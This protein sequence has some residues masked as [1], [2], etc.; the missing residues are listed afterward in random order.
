M[1]KAIKIGTR[2]SLLALAQATLVQQQLAQKGIDSTLVPLKTS[3]DAFQDKRLA[4]VGGKAL[5]TKEIDRALLRGEIDVAVHSMKDVETT[6]P[7]GLKIAGVLKREDPRD[8]FLSKK[9]SSFD[10]LPPQVRVGTCSPRRAAQVQIRYPQADI[11]LFRGNIHTRLEKLERQEVDV[12]FLALAGL[13]RAKLTSPIG[14]PLDPEIMV[15]AAG[16][17]VI[18]LECLETRED[19]EVLLGSLSHESTRVCLDLE[20][21]FLSYLEGSCHTPVGAFVVE[22]EDVEGQYFMRTF[23]ATNPMTDGTT[24]R[25]PKT[26]PSFLKKNLRG[27]CKDLVQDIENLGKEAKQ[28]LLRKQGHGF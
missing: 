3:G 9:Y 7:P 18:G 28:W 26:A 27:S 23:V 24:D 15:P 25:A 12:T 21:R 8:V 17:G 22:E 5:F 13:K 10:A 4:D 14:T 1:K 16:Q 11:V 19:L 6:R 20:R 2:G